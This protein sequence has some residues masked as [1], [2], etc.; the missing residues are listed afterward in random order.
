MNSFIISHFSSCPIV[1]MFHN[2]KLNEIINNIHE[3]AL[4]IAYKNFNSSF[5]E[6][7]IEDNSL[8]NHHKNLQKLVT[9]SSKLKMTYH[10]SSGMMFLSLSKNQSPYKQLR[11]SG[12]GR[13]IQQNMG[14]KHFLTLTSN[15][16][17]LHQ[18][19]IKLLNHLKVLKTK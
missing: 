7:L 1:W 12:R 17:T 15:Y 2:T 18:M 10:R 8:N 16:G 14:K 4:K 6:L 19:N 13:S 11:I 9:E 3:K 5:Q